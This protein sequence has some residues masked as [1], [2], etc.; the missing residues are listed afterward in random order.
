MDKIN[1]EVER[2][3]MKDEMMGKLKVYL[4]SCLGLPR[5]TN[6]PSFSIYF[7]ASPDPPRPYDSKRKW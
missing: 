2:E 7:L 6:I 1:T 4:F 3:R 5:D